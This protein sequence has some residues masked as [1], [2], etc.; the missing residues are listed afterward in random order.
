M[1][2]FMPPITLPP[3]ERSERTL[4]TLDPA[5][6]AVLQ[7]VRLRARRRIA[8]LRKVWTESG[9]E[10]QA[11][12][13]HSEVDGYLSNADD[14]QA[15]ADWLADE[16][17][18]QEWNRALAT[19]EQQ[20]VQDSDSRLALLI[21]IF[22]LNQAETDV[23]HTCLAIA[24]EPNLGRVYAYL[25]D[26]NGRDYATESLVA[27]LFG[28][29]R[30]LPLSA[31]SP[32]K[33]W[34]LIVTNSGRAGDPSRLE[35][36]PFVRNWLLGVDDLDEA[37]IGLA[38][39]VPVPVPLS[40]WPVEETATTVASLSGGV[41]Q[42]RVRFLVAGAEGSGRRSFVAC[43]CNRL[44]LPL[45]AMDS[46]RIAESNWPPV[47]IR[48]QRQAYLSGYGLAWYGES[49]GERPWPSLIS[50]CGVQFI[51][52]EVSEFLQPEAGVIDYRLELPDLSLEERQRLWKE[53]VP[54]AA[55][56]P[57]GELV[58]MLQRRKTSV[59]QIVMA[60][61]RKVKTLPE[62]M[63]VLNGSSRRRLGSLAQPL[64]SSFR[65]NDLVVPDWLCQGLEDFLYEATERS[66]LW[67]NG[68]TQRLFP[69][70]KGLIA[71]FAG[72]PGTGKTMAAQVIANAL[73]LEL[74]RIDLSSMVSKYIGETSK[75]IERI[76][77]RAQRMDV[78]LLFDEAD[79]LFGKRTDIKDA[80]DRFANT[81]TNYLLQAIEQYPG[82]AI[83]A[84]NKKA[85][86]D[87]GFT[88]RLRYVLEFPKPDAS[89]RL[90]LWRGLI[91]ELSGTERVASLDKD[92]KY[93]AEAL[94]ITGAQ[95]KFSILSAL[96][97]ARKEK[98]ELAL[99]HLLRGL[100][101]ELMKEG[102]GLGRQ[103]QETLKQ[104][105]KA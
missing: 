101:R 39:V 10:G 53:M 46:D 61:N 28:Y 52:G 26:H 51:I 31:D 72:P 29:G 75:N 2:V 44:G 74:F 66:A 50:W 40:N 25:Q 18:L 99:P 57:E 82:I 92:L 81:D 43:I 67:E 96:F 36:D 19:T 89:Q 37:L 60:A 95:I 23:L 104:L 100:E 85:N 54:A 22:G 65:W 71:L 15:E 13:Y 58:E 49:M 62:A 76:L 70:G 98:T 86:I 38:Q 97:M 79:A 69:Q 16:E 41:F 7:R 27:R 59:G 6:E 93:L 73:Q 48:A 32:L 56:W 14:P 11:N 68:E 47:F 78:V 21:R 45:L 1:S 20:L 103:M 84:S 64:T 80:H 90:K 77:S 24:L 55:Q 33:T 94:E 83:L 5:I 102:R 4:G 105:S 8:W 12:D 91:G 42:E 30:C 9:K 87:A 17:G 34:G 35:C 88:R 3:D 63:E